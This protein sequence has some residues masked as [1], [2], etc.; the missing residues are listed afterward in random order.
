M[1]GFPRLGS[2]LAFVGRSG[3]GIVVKAVMSQ[4]PGSSGILIPRE[5]CVSSPLIRKDSAL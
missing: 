2:S 5:A 1:N 3:D 4:L